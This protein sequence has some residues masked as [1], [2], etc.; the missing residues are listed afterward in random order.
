VSLYASAYHP[1]QIVFAYSWATNGTHS[2]KLVNRATSGH[3]R[4]DLD[5]FIRLVQG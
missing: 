3:P 5:A 1:R 2:I 4:I